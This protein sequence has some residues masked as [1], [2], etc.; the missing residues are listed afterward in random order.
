LTLG[1]SCSAHRSNDSCAWNGHYNVTRAYTSNGLNQYTAS[2]SATLT[3]DANGNLTSDGSTSYVYDDEN[4]LVSASGGHSATLAYDPLGRLWQSVG[5]ITGT[6]DFEYDGDR[7]LE[8]FNGSGTLQRLY[9]YG[10]GEAPIAWYE[11]T[12]GTTR[13]YLLPDERGST[14][15]VADDSGNMVAINRYDEYGIPQSGNGGRF[16]YAG[17]ALLIDLGLFYAKAR[18][19]SPTLGRFLQTDP[20]GY[21]DG[22]NWYGYVGA[23][24]VNG[25]DPDGLTMMTGTRIVPAGQNGGICG[26]CSGGSLYFNG[27]AANADR[28]AAGNAGTTPSS[29][30]SAS[31]PI[32]LKPGYTGPGLY[33]TV[34]HMSDDTFRYSDPYWLDRGNP[35]DRNFLLAGGTSIR[36]PGRDSEGYEYVGKGTVGGRS[37]LYAATWFSLSPTTIA[38]K[39]NVFSAGL[40]TVGPPLEGPG[41]G[42]MSPLGSFDALVS[43]CDWCWS[44]THTIPVLFGSWKTT[45]FSVPLGSIWIG[46]LGSDAT[47]QGTFYDIWAR[48]R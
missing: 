10:A 14:V 4:H 48:R 35:F 25:T 46:I 2:G 12:G 20:I 6:T 36:S 30:T 32:S 34:Y 47:P 18:I 26:S 21:S 23:D 17:Q 45:R 39:I 22:M 24:P 44:T 15:A 42:F 16:Q 43:R 1:S 13:R 5:S 38:V 41:F 27:S 11:F 19:Y 31:P 3:Y 29:G 9:V 40:Q 28:H 33:E 7:I 8:E 37:M